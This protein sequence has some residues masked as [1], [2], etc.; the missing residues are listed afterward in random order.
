M[1]EAAEALRFEEAVLL[2]NRIEAVERVLE[3]QHVLS[4]TTRDRDAFGIHGEGN[5]TQATVLF[6][7]KG[8]VTGQRLFPLIRLALPREEI[9]SAVLKRHYDG[10][11]LVP[12]EILLPHD[13]PDTEA[14]TEWLCDR[15]GRRV[16]L[17]VPRRGEPRRLVEMAVKNARNAWQAARSP[18]SDPRLALELAADKLGLKKIPERIE[19][20]DIASLGESVAVGSKAAFT[21]GRPDRGR[22]RRYRIRTVEGIDDYGMMYEV[23]R[24][25]LAGGED[26]PDLIVVDGGKGHLRVA[27][28]A[29]RDTGTTG[30]DVVALAKESRE[31]PAGGRE[32]RGERV[33][34][35]GRKDPFD[36][37]RWPPLLFLLQQVRDEAHR[38]AQA[39]LHRRKTRDDL[40]SALDA[41]PGIGPGR[42][43]ALLTALG[44]AAAVRVAGVETLQKAGGIGKKTAERIAAYFREMPGGPA[45]S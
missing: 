38:F 24:R 41:I 32:P 19:C 5:L 18:G 44:S 11:T 20:F 21:A 8:R 9:L 35:P 10:E 34:L 28:S 22:Y 2:R 7:R 37:A 6:V 13:I 26:L 30:V 39:Y 23:L 33:Y 4:P 14:V 12:P 40:T 45:G 16:S 27:L 36:P 31:I 3:K 17:S 42:R 29:L 43:K 1:E 25:R 15:S